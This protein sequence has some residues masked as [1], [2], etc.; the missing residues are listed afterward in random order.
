MPILVDIKWALHWGTL[1]CCCYAYLCTC[2]YSRS[3]RTQLAWRDINFH[4]ILSK[5]V[6]HWFVCKTQQ[7]WNS[8]HQEYFKQSFSFLH[9][10]HPPSVTINIMNMKIFCCI[11]IMAAWV[12]SRSVGMVGELQ[13]Q[14][15]MFIL[16]WKNHS[17]FCLDSTRVLYTLQSILHLQNEY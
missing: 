7:S 5:N 4:C 14:S 3:S 11:T 17:I 13:I 15:F 6:T 1:I 9:H 16:I 8:W 10:F 12:W 2:A